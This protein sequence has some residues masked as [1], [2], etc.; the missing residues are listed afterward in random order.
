MNK[1][2]NTKV[3]I[4]KVE[5][6]S[7]YI[8]NLGEVIGEGGQGIVY[9]SADDEDIAIKLCLDKGGTRITDKDRIIKIN[10]S[11]K[12]IRFLPLYSNK[13]S[14]PLSVLK[15]HPGYIMKLVR[16]MRPI[17]KLLYSP[18]Y[19]FKGEK[20][21]I[22]LSVKKDEELSLETRYI[23]HYNETG[24]ARQRLNI[25]S[26]IAIELA[27]LHSKGIVYSDISFNNIF[28]S[29]EYNE[30][31]FI[32]A[33][34]LHYES[35]SSPGTI[36]TPGFGAPEVE[37]LTSGNTIFSD[38]YSF[39]IMAYY[40]L[41]MNHP[42]QGA[43]L[44]CEEEAGWDDSTETSNLDISDKSNK[45]LQPW[46]NDEDDDSNRTDSG[47]PY[48]FVMNDDLFNLF[49][50][51]FEEG[52]TQFLKRPSLLCWSKALA[53]TADEFIECDKCKMSYMID[54]NHSISACCPYCDSPTPIVIKISSWIVGSP[55]DD[56]SNAWEY[57]HE[58]NDNS[59]FTIPFR[60]FTS[61]SLE[62]SNIDALKV[63]E[64]DGLLT[65]IKQSHLIDFEFSHP[66]IESCNKSNCK[67]NVSDLDEDLLIYSKCDDISFISKLRIM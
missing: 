27:K 9:K 16:G 18:S 55:M 44:L 1:E 24:S 46:V 22:F 58:L 42:F 32:D 63:I 11:C 29:D 48:N 19:K 61:F 23:W 26:L 17:N 67:I 2:Q 52:K 20:P 21:P 60:T 37:Q 38:S 7:G 49:K 33:D 3:N 54:D 65:L 28:Y 62:T 43:L 41:T 50:L 40:L 14:V 34:N 66:N 47:L 59:E 6:E 25:L 36:Y 12:E 45:G 10:T 5:D 4:T 15:G 39:A 56:N 57:Y 35:K 30:V 13:I 64:K 8:I 51:M 53:A 31:C